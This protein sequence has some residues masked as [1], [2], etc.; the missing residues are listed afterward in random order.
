MSPASDPNLAVT[1]L[2]SEYDACRAITKRRARNF[3]YGL[4]LT[5][6][7]RR[8]ALFAIYAWMRKGDDIADDESNPDR[9]SERLAEFRARTQ[10]LLSDD[11]PA[12]DD[13]RHRAAS[14]SA[15]WAA[16]AHTLQAF[17]IDPKD[18][19][20]MLRGLEQD[21][22]FESPETEAEL[23]KYCA[24]V[25]STVGRVC[26]AIWG[27]RPG[28]DPR[29]ASELA[30]ARGLAFQHTNIL[31]DFAEDYDA[32]RV[33][34]PVDAFRHAELTPGA[35]RDW[36]DPRRCAEFVR[37]R[38]RRATAHYEQ[39]AR[40][41]ELIDPA[42]SPALWAMTRIYQGLLERIRRRPSSI[43][44]PRRIRLHSFSKASIA[45]RALLR[46]RA[47]SEGNGAVSRSAPR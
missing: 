35:L 28:V 15:M 42:C 44:G 7:P 45:V 21:A 34:L 23:D 33:Y 36:T 22:E 19:R 2:A 46:A 26:V 10:Q 27:V 14:S 9:R 43:A 3:Y 32:G 41:D 4:R 16:F 6:E 18:I 24:R 12:L 47:G 5:P 25:A 11:P 1:T 17:P 31:R 40:L 38:V 30:T 8:S 20:L 13:L 37:D 29:E 39:S